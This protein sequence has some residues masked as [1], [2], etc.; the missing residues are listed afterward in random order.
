MVNWST[1][2]SLS[3]KMVQSKTSLYP[4]NSLFIS[5]ILNIHI[6]LSSISDA[7]ESCLLVLSWVFVSGV[8][9]I[10]SGID[11]ALLLITCAFLQSTQ[12]S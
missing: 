7:V 3:R 11:R 12:Y 8:N 9:R 10:D 5:I 2:Q 4:F 6:S 1:A